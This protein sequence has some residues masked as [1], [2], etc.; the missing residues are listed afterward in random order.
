MEAPSLAKMKLSVVKH[1]KART[2]AETAACVMNANI[3]IG[4]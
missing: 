3:C 4:S 1:L 2:A